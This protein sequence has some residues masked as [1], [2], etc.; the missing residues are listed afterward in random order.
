MVGVADGSGVGVT[1]AVGVNVLEGEGVQVVVWVGVIVVGM[2][3]AISD[4][5][6]RQ[7]ENKKTNSKPRIRSFLNVCC[8]ML[9][10]ILDHFLQPGVLLPGFDIECHQEM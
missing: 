10:P 3:S 4:V 6:S 5:L 9:L 8:F 7:A 1:V 2:T